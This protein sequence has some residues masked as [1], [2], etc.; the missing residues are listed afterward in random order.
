[1]EEE[2]RARATDFVAEHWR[3]IQAIAPE[4]L[5]SN[6]LDDAEA[7]LVLQAAGGD[8]EAVGRLATY[9]RLRRF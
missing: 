3:E 5:K 2:L 1:L 4:L 6:T 8:Q 7:E 9:R